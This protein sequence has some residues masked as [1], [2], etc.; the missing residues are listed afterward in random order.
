VFHLQIDATQ[1][2]DLAKGFEAEL[3]SSVQE[4]ARDLSVML[5]ARAVELSGEKLH[6]R[7]E[8]Y[9]RAL[10]LHEEEGAFVLALD[11][12]ANWVED[13]LPARNLLESLLKSPKAKRGLDGSKYL[14]VPFELGPGKGPTNTPA[15]TLD[16]VNTVKAEMKKRRIPMGV[17]RDDQGR[18]KLGRLHKFD[19]TSGPMKTHQAPGQ[20]WGRIGDVKQGPNARQ[21]VGGG[22]AGGG[23][24]FLQGVNVYQTAVAGGGVKRSISTFR[25]ASSKHESP[26]WDVKELEG[27]HI[28]ESLEKWAA[29]QVETMIPQIIENLASKL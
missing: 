25:V 12:S 7:R 17:E 5:H 15:S 22:P 4:A 1:L 9:I 2:Q 14:V 26:R 10:S 11:A 6:S 24:P 28:F 20:G 27:V 18:P 16:L 19:I 29:E 23:T 21:A 13:G 3:K 8:M